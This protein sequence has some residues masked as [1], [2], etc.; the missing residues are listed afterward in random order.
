MDLLIFYRRGGHIEF[1]RFKEYC[2]SEKNGP[3][4]ASKYWA[5]I[6]DRARAP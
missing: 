6:S 3:K 5:S 1:I 2:R 4:S